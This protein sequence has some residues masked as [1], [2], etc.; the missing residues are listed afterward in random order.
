MKVLDD[1]APSGYFEAL[2]NVTLSRLEDDIEMQTVNR[3][4]DDSSTGIPP[5]ADAARDEDSGLHDIRSL[6]SSTKLRM[7]KKMPAVQPV[8]DDILASSSAGWKAMALPEPAKMISLPELAHLPDASEVKAK[9]KATRKAEAKAAKADIAAAPAAAAA[10]AADISTAPMIGARFAQQQKSKTGLYAAVGIALAAAAGVGIYLKVSAKGEAPATVASVETTATPIEAPAAQKADLAAATPPPPVEPAP[11]P[12]AAVLPAPA[13]SGSAVASGMVVAQEEV[14]DGDDKRAGKGRGEKKNEKASGQTSETV[15]AKPDKAP[16]KPAA[17][18]Q[19]AP[20][21]GGGEEDPSFDALLKEAGVEKTKDKGP[22]LDKKSLSSGD[23]KA[24]MNG[25]SDKAKG[26]YSGT[27][28]TATV[29]LTVA[30]DGKVSKVKVSGVFAGTPTGACIESAV[31]GAEF[32]AWD[33]GPQSVSYSY[34][35]AE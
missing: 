7:S 2:P 21:A 1:E 29:K 14:S 18:A 33:G 16:V 26:C 9:D 6:A 20:G 5:Q 24:A 28:G 10:T 30:P 11:A 8:D 15:T 23:I 12:A 17:P 32:P 4:T 27:E 35:L 13:D 3:M 25:V 22:K 34:L 31:R 19:P